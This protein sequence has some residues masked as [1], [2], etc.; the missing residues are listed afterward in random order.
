M[1]GD[2]LIVSHQVTGADPEIL[3]RGGALCRPTDKENFKFQMV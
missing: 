1:L 3:K 2:N